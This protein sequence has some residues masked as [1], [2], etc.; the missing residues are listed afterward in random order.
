MTRGEDM[1]LGTASMHLPAAASRC[2]LLGCAGLFPVPQKVAC[3]P[4]TVPVM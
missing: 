3:S 4:N 1:R 2:M